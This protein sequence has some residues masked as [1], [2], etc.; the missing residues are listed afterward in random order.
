VRKTVGFVFGVVLSVVLSTVIVQ[1]TQAVTVDQIKKNIRAI[2]ENFSSSETEF[3]FIY[4]S[5]IT[6]DADG[7]ATIPEVRMTEFKNGDLQGVITIAQ[8]KLSYSGEVLQKLEVR[9]GVMSFE[10]KDRGISFSKLVLEQPSSIAFLFEDSG[11]FFDKIKTRILSGDLNFEYLTVDQINIFDDKVFELNIEEMRLDNLQSGILETTRFTDVRIKSDKT[12]DVERMSI[13]SV[14][15]RNLDT[16]NIQY[17]DGKITYS[18]LSGGEEFEIRGLNI[19]LIEAFEA[20]SVER[21]YLGGV[22]SVDEQIVSSTMEMTGLTIPVDTVKTENPMFPVLMEKLGQDI[23]KID[24]EFGFRINTKTGTLTASPNRVNID[25]LGALH[26]DLEVVGL[27]LGEFARSL[28]D[29][30]GQLI[31]AG[32][33]LKSASFRYEDD[34]FAD[35]MI[36]LNG[37]DKDVLVGLVEAKL[38]Q[39][40]KADPDMAKRAGTAV[41]DFIFGTNFLRIFVEADG[42]VGLKDIVEKWQAGK[43]G[44]ILKVTFK[45]G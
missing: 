6:V 35:I 44:E 34:K 10:N 26:V 11:K 9:N 32:V 41:R 18:A 3:K 33:S 22:E 38:W 15:A 4:G 28:T 13:K 42:L 45:G 31:N 2:E 40:F 27:K 29:G 20:T 7:L 37:G 17:D 12:G 25:G 5:E 36:D 30:E 21:V 39:L 19:D 8:V 43:L 23:L 14:Y 16:K 1:P 24:A